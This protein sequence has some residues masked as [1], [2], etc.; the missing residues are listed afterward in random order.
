MHVTPALWGQTLNVFYFTICC[1]ELYD[2]GALEWSILR[3]YEAECPKRKSYAAPSNG[4]RPETDNLID[5]LSPE[6]TYQSSLFSKKQYL[7][8]TGQ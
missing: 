7:L 1:D 5:S 4:V 8:N 2:A 6:S 3:P